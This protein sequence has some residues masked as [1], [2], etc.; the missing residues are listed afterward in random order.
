FRGHHRASIGKSNLHGVNTE[1]VNGRPKR[2]RQNSWFQR[3]AHL[4]MQSSPYLRKLAISSKHWLL[5]RA[6]L[7]FKCSSITLT[8]ESLTLPASLTS[9]RDSIRHSL[10]SFTSVDVTAER[11]STTGGWHS[12]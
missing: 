4:T 10:E 8:R 1:M 5:E 11:T 7:L 9:V 3:T 12:I 6:V 2:F